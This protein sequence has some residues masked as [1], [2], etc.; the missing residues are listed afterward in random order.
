MKFSK[1]V[2][3]ALGGNAI[4][5]PKEKGSAKEQFNNVEK[6]C[7]QIAGMIKKGFKVVV[8][9][10]NGPQVGNILIQN[11]KAKD[12]VPAMPLDVCGAESQGQIGYMIQ[13]RL[14]NLFKEMSI[15]YS[16]ATIITQV[17]VDKNDS[18]FTHPTKPIGPFYTEKEA[19]EF[20]KKNQKEKWIE[21]SGRGW[22]KVVP[23]PEPIGI[24]EKEAI[25]A[26][27]E[28]NVVVVASGG[29]GIPVTKK[30]GGFQGVEA[31]IDKDL[32]GERLAFDVRTDIFM[33]LTDV[34]RV[35]INF[36]KSY[37][38]DLD[39]MNLSQA[40]TYLEEGHF[41]PGSMGPKVKAAI[42][43]VESGGEYAIICSSKQALDAFEGKT[44]TWIVA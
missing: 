42:K 7:R 1:R 15:P 22:R 4:L 31:V 35:A 12:I 29:G 41:P 6:T 18:A 3:V 2:V 11:E 16:V 34:S 14:D 43:F 20:I 38:K 30:N 21:D 26:L 40:K 37:Q 10:G 44:G 24:V 33:M 39:R 17:V 9:H 8:T 36:G 27:L 19:K 28:K 13:Q 32:A 23:S 25:K 5:R